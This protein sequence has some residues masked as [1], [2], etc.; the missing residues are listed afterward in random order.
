VNPAKISDADPQIAAVS[1]L[2]AWVGVGLRP[3]DFANI[4][5]VLWAAI[6]NSGGLVL[7]V[8]F[9]LTRRSVRE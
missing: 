9:G 8:G 6:L 7:A 4:R 1:R 2:A 5:L 3:D